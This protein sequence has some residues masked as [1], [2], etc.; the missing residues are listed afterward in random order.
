MAKIRVST[1]MDDWKEDDQELA[2]DA[3]EDMFETLRVATMTIRR[4]KIQTLGGS[5]VS[6]IFEVEPHRVGSFCSLIEWTSF[7]QCE[8]VGN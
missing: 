8:I 6:Q 3:V 1:D 7:I 5:W 2:P 4:G